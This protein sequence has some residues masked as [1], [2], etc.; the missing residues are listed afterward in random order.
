MQDRPQARNPVRRPDH[1]GQLPATLP[2]MASSHEDAGQ[3]QR[4]HDRDDEPVPLP[5]G[6]L[7]VTDLVQGPALADVATIEILSERAICRGE[8]L[9][10]Q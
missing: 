2:V 1:A 5:A 9:T 6:A 8:V 3:P 4:T 10:E 7:P